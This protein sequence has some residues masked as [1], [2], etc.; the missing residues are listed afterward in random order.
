ML[1]KQQKRKSDL[2]RREREIM[3]II[4][5]LGQATVA[6]V[7]EAMSEPPSYSAVRSTLGILEK[8]GHLNHRSDGKSYVYLPTAD[9]RSAR[10]SALD[11]LLKTFFNDS[12]ADAVTAL[13]RERGDNL[14]GEEIERL[15]ELIGEARREGR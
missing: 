11:H 12:A 15:T 10:S 7:L 1:K 6:E 3:D 8:K 13:L 9:R 14:S 4:F 5:R 2:S